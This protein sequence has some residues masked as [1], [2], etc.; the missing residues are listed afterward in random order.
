MQQK[1]F[2]VEIVE[3][4]I[5]II[6]IANYLPGPENEIAKL[7]NPNYTPRFF[8]Y[9]FNL[10]ENY[11]FSGKIPEFKYFESQFESKE[12]FKQKVSF[13]E[14]FKGSWDF[15]TEIKQ[16]SKEKS[17][18]LCASTCLFLKE[19]IQLQQDVQL[20]VDSGNSNKHKILLPFSSNICTFSGFMYNLFRGLFLNNEI[21][22]SIHN[23]YHVPSR[24]VSQ[25]EYEFCKCLEFKFPQH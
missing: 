17:N 3:L 22:Y 14:N 2:T 16:F 11:T 18:L 25:A 15:G 21:I 5:K 13:F 23:E 6:N 4:K 19:L 8:P 1:Y 12:L 9:K 24:K 20:V 10:K 7:C